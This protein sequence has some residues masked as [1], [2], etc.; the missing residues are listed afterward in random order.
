MA[1]TQG[2]SYTLAEVIRLAIEHRLATLH[3]AIPGKIKSYDKDKNLAEIEVQVRQFFPPNEIE[4]ETAVLADVPIQWPSINDR[5]FITFPLKPEM[6]GMIHFC[7]RSIGNW[8][9]DDGNKAP[10]EHRRFDLSDA[11]FVPGMSPVGKM[12]GAHDKDIVIR[13]DGG[14]L[15]LTPDGKFQIMNSSEELVTVL[16]DLVGELMA[17]KTLTS[18]GP[19]PF[20]ADVVAKLTQ[21]QTR[22]QAFKV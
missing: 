7:E 20:T 2:R 16:F 8:L 12:P 1:A 6:T 5:C 9:M 22:L 11:F 19:Q 17:A 18:I 14:E 10:E 13:N 21:I 4:V 15:H 3:T